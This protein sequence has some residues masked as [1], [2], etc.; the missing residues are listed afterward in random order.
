MA[1]PKINSPYFP[2]EIPSSK[3]KISIRPFT[4]KE[5]KLLLMAA[6]S[7]DN[8]FILSTINQ[9]LQNCI[10]EDSLDVEDLA[11]F[12]TEFLFINIRAR[13]VSNVMEV[14]FK[15]EEDGNFYDGKVDLDDV[16]VNFPD[17]HSNIID[18][19]DRYKVTLKYPTFKSLSSVKMVEHD[20]KQIPDQSEVVIN[21]L[22]KLID[23]DTDEVTNISE[24]TKEEITEFF[25]SFTAQNMR[26]IEK[27]FSSM[28]TVTVKIP[29]ITKDN[30][31]KVREIQGLYNFFT[32]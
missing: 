16:K 31:Q 6:Q 30:Q 21:S 15:D 28:P 24:A 29:Y 4:V 26:D 17:G 3:K 27:F 18:L 2:L 1:L 20:E 22:D 10:R 25:E 5:E 11:T 12:D 8:K 19:D 23:N 7:K 14:R 32:S 13:S 9:I